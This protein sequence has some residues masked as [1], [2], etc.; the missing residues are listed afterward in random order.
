MNQYRRRAS[1][2]L[3]G[4]RTQK[5]TGKR[6]KRISNHTVIRWLVCCLPIGWILMWHP[7]CKW[8]KVNKVNITL[9]TVAALTIVICGAA[10]ILDQSQKTTGGVQLVSNKPLVEAYGPEIPEGVTYTFADSNTIEQAVVV[11]PEPTVE[12]ETAY[13]NDGGKY[14]HTENCRYVKE[15]TRCY[16]VTYLLNQG[17]D[18]CEECAAGA[19]A[20]EYTREN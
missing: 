3:S 7:G 1:N 5:K 15:Y 13:C 2:V 20:A 16:Y 4:A 19:L 18:P 11:T 12:P 9:A 8:K 10:L 6:A 17:F 14:F